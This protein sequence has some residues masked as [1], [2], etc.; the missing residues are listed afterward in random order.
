[1]PRE[2]PQEE[3]RVCVWL[4][5]RPLVVRGELFGQEEKAVHWTL[6]RPISNDLFGSM[7][8]LYSL[9]Q[10]IYQIPRQDECLSLVG[11]PHVRA[12]VIGRNVSTVFYDNGT[13]LSAHFV[14]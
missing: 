11:L 1:M 7:A 3:L 13:L 8:L 4:S 2:A 10:Y 14:G 9:C 5:C 6:S 12:Q